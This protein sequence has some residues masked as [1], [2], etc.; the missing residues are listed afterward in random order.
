MT[1]DVTVPR[2]W[3]ELTQEQLRFLLSAMVSVNRASLH[4]AFPSREAY[5]A[6]TVARV[7][8]LC[9]LRWTGITL[10]CPC[11]SGYI[12]RHAGREFTLTA[13]VLASAISHLDWIRLPPLEPVRLDSVDGAE[14]IPADLST[15]LSFDSWLACETLW[16]RYQ[17]DPDDTLLKQM[18]AILYRKED[19]RP[20]DAATLGIFFW[21]AGVKN[22]VSVQFPD[23]FKTVGNDEE[24]LPPTYDEIRRGIDAQIRALTKGDIT[25]EREILVL[26]AM[27]ALTELDAQAR[28]YE[29]LRR[30]YNKK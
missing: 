25:K 23:F 2:S 21:W 9:F 4:T 6:N 20:D 24:P 12:F 16:Q 28:E 17:L 29:E 11:T 8:T 27:R 3:T 5:V 13:A 30:R 14:A 1:I 18:A 26:D 10:V 22:L 15:G 7:Q 19:I